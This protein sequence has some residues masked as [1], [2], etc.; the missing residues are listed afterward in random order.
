M[1]KIEDTEYFYDM[2]ALLKKHYIS[3]PIR[4]KT[5]D[6]KSD[7]DNSSFI[8]PKIMTDLSNYNKVYECNLPNI[9]CIIYTKELTSK[10]KSDV[11]LMMNRFNTMLSFLKKNNIDFNTDKFTFIYISTSHQKIFPDKNIILG[12]N[13]INSGASYLYQNKLY[14]WRE[15]EC[16]KVF[17]HELFHCLGFDRFLIKKKCNINKYFNITK[18]LSCN[19]AYNELC[20]LIY[21]SC[22][23]VI[24][25]KQVD[26]IEL[27]EKN[28]LFTVYQVKQILQH[29]D[30]QTLNS[31][32][33]FKQNTSVFSYFILKGFYLFHINELIKLIK[34]DTTYFFPINEFKLFES[35]KTNCLENNSFYDLI[36]RAINKFKY[37]EQSTLCM[38][39]F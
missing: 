22:F 20:T 21:H 17:L 35:Y 34:T 31:S 16:L 1:E 15:E 18:H 36:N 8:S 13:E 2:L 27:I 39:V 26:L 11:K 33:K 38:T 4:F 30:C 32:Y 10:V 29:Y 3:R 37:K 7:L 25:N 23:M 12:P 19:E 28:R 6:K 9:T 5:S 24:E 14:V